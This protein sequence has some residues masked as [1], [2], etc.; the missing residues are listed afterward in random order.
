MFYDI[1]EVKVV[2]NYVLYIRFEDGLS[3]E[4]DISKIVPLEG[5]FF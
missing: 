5:V 2:K 4:I 1:V 3:G